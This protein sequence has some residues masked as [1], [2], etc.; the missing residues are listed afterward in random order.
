MFNETN[1]SEKKKKNKNGEDH[2]KL[3]SGAVFKWG[4]VLSLK[5]MF[6]KF[7]FI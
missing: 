6:I 4:F 7:L 3:S 1:I 2:I 5:Q